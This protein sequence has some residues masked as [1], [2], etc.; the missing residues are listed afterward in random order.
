MLMF[1]RMT[2]RWL[3]LLVLRRRGLRMR[4]RFFLTAVA[5]GNNGDGGCFLRLLGCATIPPPAV[6]PRAPLAASGLGLLLLLLRIVSGEQ[7]ETDRR[8]TTTTRS[9]RPPNS[10]RNRRPRRSESSRRRD[11]KGGRIPIA[12]GRPARTTTSTCSGSACIRGAE[13]RCHRRRCC[14]AEQRGGPSPLPHYRNRCGGCAMY[15]GI[16][17]DIYIC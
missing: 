17:N 14:Q 4:I 2:I 9:A 7:L 1:R 6:T 3:P 8:A 12:T 10:R 13:E 15:V 5:I 16:P 11:D